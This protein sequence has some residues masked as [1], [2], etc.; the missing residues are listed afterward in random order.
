[1]TKFPIINSIDDVLEIEKQPLDFYLKEQ[2]TYQIIERAANRYQLNNAMTF[3]PNGYL[4]ENETKRETNYK[5]LFKMVNG[6]A[7]YFF[8]KGIC[9]QDVVSLMLPN[10]PDTH[11]LIW[12]V[13]TVAIVNPI[14]TSFPKEITIT[15]LKKAKTKYLIVT[16]YIEKALINAIRKECPELSVIFLNEIAIKLSTTLNFKPNEDSER[17]CAYFHTSGTTGMPKLACFNHY[18]FV[19]M[20][21]ACNSFFKYTEQD[22]F[23]L[24]LPLF[25][26]AASIIGQLASAYAGS[27]IVILSPFGWMMPSAIENIWHT[28]ETFQVTS[29]AALPYIYNKLYQQE[30]NNFDITSL[31]TMISGMPL[32]ESFISLFESHIGINSCIY[33]SYGLT[34]ATCLVAVDFRLPYQKIITSKLDKNIYPTSIMDVGE[35]VITGPN[36]IKN[37]VGKNEMKKLVTGDLAI[38]E[39]NYLSI[40]DRIENLIPVDNNILLSPLV[41]ETALISHPGIINAAVIG[42]NN[43]DEF[44]DIY[45]FIQ[46]KDLGMN[47]EDV[48]YFLANYFEG[49]QVE[50]EFIKFVSFLPV[51]A[52]GKLD[53]ITLKKNYHLDS[54]F[55]K[56]SA[57]IGLPRK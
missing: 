22:V 40:L 7:N 23:L 48:L 39:N 20:A 13:Q 18:N 57:D 11:A 46:T 3:L 4:K 55:S 52:M 19:Y 5:Q 17:V 34:E 43:N 50:I 42:V 30:I 28:I 35:L 29:I 49:W 33:N 51:N 8:N 37:Y 10:S 31:K 44:Q 54:F 2:T 25:H 12:A 32:S 24:G 27:S 16:E 26:V 9:E 47:I 45:F 36:I 15:L 53:R 6:Y 1:M 14:N 21:W 41:V 56:S 38:I